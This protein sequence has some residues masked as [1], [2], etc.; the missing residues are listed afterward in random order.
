MSGNPARFESALAVHR[1]IKRRLF[2]LA[3]QFK[4]PQVKHLL[5]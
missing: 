4:M 3:L 5:K 1:L 2:S